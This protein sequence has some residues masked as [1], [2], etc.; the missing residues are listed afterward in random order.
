MSQILPVSTPFHTLTTRTIP[1]TQ[2]LD[3]DLVLTTCLVSQT[4][5]TT[6]SISV[7]SIH[8]HGSC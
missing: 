8:H 4:L 6:N 3:W 1:Q 7:H 2:F 5:P